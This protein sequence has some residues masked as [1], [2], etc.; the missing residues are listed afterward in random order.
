MHY[1]KSWHFLTSVFP[2]QL[3]MSGQWLQVL[4]QE[5]QLGTNPGSVPYQLYNLD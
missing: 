5:L 2:L 3:R 4:D 1:G